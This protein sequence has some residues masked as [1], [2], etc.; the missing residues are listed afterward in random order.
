MHVALCY[1]VE[2]S[3][4]SHGKLSSIPCATLLIGS[5]LGAAHRM[6]KSVPWDIKER[7]ARYQRTSQKSG[8]RIIKRAASFFFLT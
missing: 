4:S 1:P 6:L 5:Y 7:S 3:L 2:R 8:S